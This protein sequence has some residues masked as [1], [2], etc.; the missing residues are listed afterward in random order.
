MKKSIVALAL[1]ITAISGTAQAQNWVAPLVAGVVAGAV[2]NSAIHP[3][4]RVNYGYGYRPVQGFFASP[5][6]GAY[7]PQPWDYERRPYCVDTVV[8]YDQM[9]QPVVQRV[10]Q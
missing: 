6:N 1:L 3:Q 8:G 5:A 9:G 7:G 10:C 4:P 2:I